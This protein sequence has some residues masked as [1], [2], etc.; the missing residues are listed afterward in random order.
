MPAGFSLHKTVGRFLDNRRK[1]IETGAGIDWAMAEALAFGTLLTEGHPVRL[2][3]QDVERGTFS[4]R[5]S[6]LF[7]QDTEERF[8]PLNEFANGPARF[9]VINSMLSERRCSASSTA[10]RSPTPTR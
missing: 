10:I 3:G 2:S 4:Q 7:D 1:A 6:V 9:E 5:H 8:I